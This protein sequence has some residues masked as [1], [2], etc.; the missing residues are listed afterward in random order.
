MEPRTP[1]PQCLSGPRTLATKPL[2]WVPSCSTY[3][4]SNLVLVNHAL[5]G[6]QYNHS[7]ALGTC[8]TLKQPHSTTAIAHKFYLLEFFFNQ[9]SPGSTSS[10]LPSPKEPAHT[11]QPQLPRCHSQSNPTSLT[12]PATVHIFT[13]ALCPCHPQVLP[14][15]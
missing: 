12:R 14:V 8:H 2:L 10:R 1:T 4:I 13:S 15:L 5:N 11:Q 9:L 6:P 7:H 3:S